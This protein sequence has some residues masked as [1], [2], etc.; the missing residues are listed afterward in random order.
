MTLDPSLLIQVESASYSDASIV[1]GLIGNN[2]AFAELLLL[3][4]LLVDVVGE[5]HDFSNVVS[6]LL[7]LLLVGHGGQDGGQGSQRG[8]SKHR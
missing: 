4:Q 7:Q 6:T 2:G 5:E 8:V 1:G 3:G